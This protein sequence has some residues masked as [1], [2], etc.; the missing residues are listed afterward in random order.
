MKSAIGLAWG[1]WILGLD[2]LET[3]KILYEHLKHDKK[4]G[5]GGYADPNNIDGNLWTKKN[6]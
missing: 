3:F 5:S 4:F 2:E 1:A 6:R